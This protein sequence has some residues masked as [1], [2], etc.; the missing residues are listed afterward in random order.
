MPELERSQ[1]LHALWPLLI[2]LAADPFLVRAASILALEGPSPFTL[3][4]PWVELVHLPMF[5]FTGETMST[6]T[7]WVLYLQ[8]PVYGLLMTLL[9]RADKRLRTLAVGIA[10]HFGGVAL[11]VL[12]S[13]L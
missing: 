4:Y 1:P 12:L 10:A 2:C 9:Y 13:Y 6:L 7:Q 8:F 5:H 11:V 3:L